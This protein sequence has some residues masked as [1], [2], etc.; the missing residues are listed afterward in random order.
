[1]AYIDAEKTQTWRYEDRDN[2]RQTIRNTLMFANYTNVGKRDTLGMETKK[3]ADKLWMMLR[4]SPNRPFQIEVECED[5][6]LVV[7]GIALGAW[8]THKFAVKRIPGAKIGKV[9]SAL[10]EEINYPVEP[11]NR[12]IV[13]T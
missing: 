13:S 4:E 3:L 7:L 11:D 5:G 12:L 6:S 1:M 10:W 8:G 2:F 9:K